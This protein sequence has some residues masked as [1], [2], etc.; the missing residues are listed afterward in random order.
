MRD[1]YYDKLLN[2]KTGGIQ[3]GFNKSF[4]NHRYE[5]TPFSALEILIDQYEIKSSD[6]I[7]DFGC[8]K[9]RL[10]FFMNYLYDAT[11]VGIE[12]NE[13]LYEEAMDNRLNYLKK[14]KTN[15]DKIEF[16]CCYAQDY[17]INPEDNRFYFFNPFSIQVFHSIVNNIL[18]SL[19][20]TSREVELV[21]YYPS[22]DYIYFLENQTFFELKK[23]VI[24]PDLFEHNGNER[25]L[26]YSLSFA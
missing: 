2:I 26:I 18:I 6:R 5:P 10:N 22:E 9:G 13:L 24:L 23:E 17:E 20:T 4:H 8:G 11:V 7:V 25:F 12:M 1:H 16:H 3:Q 14:R 21:L 19:E 15:K